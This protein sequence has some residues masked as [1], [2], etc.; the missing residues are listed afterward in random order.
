MSKQTIAII[1]GGKSSEYFVSLESSYSVLS[2]IDQNKFDI[3]MI[4]ISQD[5]KWKHFIGN[6]EKIKENTWDSEKLPSVS[7]CLDSTQ[8]ALLEI[9]NH[10]VQYIHVDA[11]FPILHGLN[12][13]DGSVQGA[14]QLSHIPLIGCDVLSSSLCMDKYRA[15]QL[16]EKNGIA[17]PRSIFIENQKD[18]KLKRENILALNLP[19]YIKPIHAGSSL[20][21]SKIHS[22]EQL[23]QAVAKS[24]EYDHE[25]VVEEEIKGFEVGCAVMG[26]DQLTVGRVDE[27]ELSHGFF[28]FEEKYSLKTSKIHMPARID[29]QLEKQIQETAKQIYKILGCRVFARVDM[30]LT[31]DHTIVFNE[32]NTIPGFTAHSR[33]PNMMKGIQL[34]FQQLLTNLIEIGIND[35]NNRI[36]TK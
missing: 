11:I 29:A 1:F 9:K 31:P 32:I 4:G 5:G 6:I 19:L 20:G 25:I 16:V 3:Y 30:F 10:Q 14:I 22:F 12:G 35:A 36:N 15:H 27:I 7:I 23:D 21:I 33:Y 26:I 28:D 24:F 13:E 18:Y 2:H 8:Q 34:D 17:V